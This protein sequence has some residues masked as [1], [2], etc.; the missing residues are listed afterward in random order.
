MI[1][2][3][4]KGKKNVLGEY[5][6]KDGSQNCRKNDQEAVGSATSWILSGVDRAGFQRLGKGD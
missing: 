5:W 3:D 6:W 1:L 4:R 2:L